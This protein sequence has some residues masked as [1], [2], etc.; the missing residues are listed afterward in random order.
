MSAWRLEEENERQQT[1]FS[2]QRCCG[3]GYFARNKF[4]NLQ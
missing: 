4:P 1:R 3:V 2:P